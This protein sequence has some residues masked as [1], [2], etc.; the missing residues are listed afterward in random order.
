M[1]EDRII[2]ERHA[3]GFRH[4]GGGIHAAGDLVDYVINCVAVA[5]D[6]A[7]VDVAADKNDLGHNRRARVMG[8]AMFVDRVKLCIGESSNDHGANSLSVL[9]IFEIGANE[10]GRSFSRKR[11]WVE[12][13]E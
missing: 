5:N 1:T 2:H 11:H 4:H 12:P 8:E 10:R 7:V 3:S 13:E 6:P 9:N